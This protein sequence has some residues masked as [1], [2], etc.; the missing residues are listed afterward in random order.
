MEKLEWWGYPMVY[1]RM[2]ITVYT[3]Y[4]RVTDRQT[5]GHVAMA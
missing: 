3:Q 5:D 2:C 4:G 1:P